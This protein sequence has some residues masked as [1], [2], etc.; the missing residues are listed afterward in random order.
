MCA[1]SRVNL[2]YRAGKVWR[3]TL[4][5]VQLL[6]EIHL[7]VLLS[8]DNGTVYDARLWISDENQL[9]KRGA[10]LYTAGDE[11]EGPRVEEGVREGRVLVRVGSDESPREDL[12]HQRF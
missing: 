1:G 7:R 3:G 11:D 4:C 2:E 5:G 10:H 8:I 6:K 9:P 12:L